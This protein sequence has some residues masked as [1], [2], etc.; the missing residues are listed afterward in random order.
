MP[1]EVKPGD[2][3]RVTYGGTGRPV[4]G[5]VTVS[6]PAAKVDWQHDHQSLGTKA[7]RPPQNL[8]TPA[9]VRAWNS[10]DAVRKAQRNQ[11]NY[12]V[13][14]ETDGSF[15]IDDVLAGT[16]E[17]HLNLTDPE[18]TSNNR[19]GMDRS[20]GTLDKE[21]VVPEMPNGRSDEPLDV[22]S[23]ILPL[24]K[25]LKI[26]DPAPLFELNTPEDQPLKL[27][28]YRGKYV[29]LSFWTSPVAAG[30]ESLTQLK[31]VYDAFGKD[32]RFVMIGLNI[33]QDAAEVREFTR[34]NQMPWVHGLAGEWA[35]NQTLAAY[36]VEAL[37]AS[38][39]IDPD[40]KLIA[41]GLQ[42]PAI[43]PATERALRGPRGM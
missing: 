19:Y 43:R 8:K 27:A 40:G 33:G 30:E 34:A 25:Q 11:R 2:V 3:T 36:G 31:S 20:I 18:D 42:G 4:T 16:Y 39:L 15:R 10:S 1:I 37:P 5:K 6:D 12:S 17:L 14:F 13:Q 23:L 41:T 29:L 35:N 22:G 26:G 28:N 32:D 38:F 21:I 7:P 24:K 9:E